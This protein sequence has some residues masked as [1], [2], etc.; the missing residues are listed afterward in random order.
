MSKRPDEAM[1]YTPDPGRR[2]G[3][4]R[5]PVLALLVVLVLAGVSWVMSQDWWALL[6]PG[7][8]AE[9]PPVRPPAPKTPPVTLP[10]Y[11]PMPRLS[12]VAEVANGLPAEPGDDPEVA[13]LRARLADLER[14]L[15][16]TP[17]PVPSAPIGPSVPADTEAQR[18]QRRQQAAEERK[19][20]EQEQKAWK[21]GGGSLKRT[22][23]EQKGAL[24]TLTTPWSLPP[25][26]IINCRTSTHLSN[27]VQGAF[28]GEVTR[29]VKTLDG[30]PVLPQGTKLLGV[31][32]R[33]SIAGDSRMTV[34]VTKI[35][36]PNW[37]HLDFPKA[38]LADQAGT[39]G[40]TGEITR[41]LARQ[42]FAAVTIG[43]LRAGSTMVGGGLGYGMGQDP[44]AAIGG[45]VASETAQQGQQT[46]RQAVNTAPTINVKRS[47]GCL[48]ILE[49]E[50]VLPGPYPL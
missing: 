16:E 13:A 25:T 10:T 32:T 11:T 49:D 39:A 47:T 18:Q 40:L 5:T 14:R 45:A 7:T 43:A 38:T 17:A 35:T 3:W 48:M 27:E 37:T 1:S 30:V 28:L 50:L 12:A 41:H 8:T 6:W 46:V 9:S 31:P 2:V 4:P 42:V 26:T 33:A 23:A 15:A 44:A 21:S 34:A 24:K 20:R 36:F 19:R 22:E 29:T